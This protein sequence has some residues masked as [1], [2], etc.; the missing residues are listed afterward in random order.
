MIEEDGHGNRV[1]T[2]T[3]VC[4]LYSKEFFDARDLYLQTLPYHHLSLLPSILFYHTGCRRRGEKRG[5]AKV[6]ETAYM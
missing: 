3:F 2:I 6:E 1:N 4:I 5:R